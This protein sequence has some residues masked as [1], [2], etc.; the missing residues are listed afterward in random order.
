ML[1]AQ[2][3]AVARRRERASVPLSAV[4][5]AP[6]RL[7]LGG[8]ACLVGELRLVDLAALEAWAAEQME[9][10]LAGLPPAAYDP[11]PATRRGR[12]LA[13][14]PAARAW[15]PRFGAGACRDLLASPAGMVA[16][17]LVALRRFDASVDEAAAGQIAGSM[18]PAEWGA[19]YRE[20]YGSPAWREVL[21]ELDPDDD[22][23]DPVDWCEAVDEVSRERGWSYDQVG[24]LTIGQWR[25][26]RSHGSAPVYRMRPRP[27]ET[28]AEVM[29]RE[30]A[31]FGREG[32]RP[33]AVGTQPETG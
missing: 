15:P 3:A 26:V 11:E 30:R 33:S 14:W 2:A 31:I 1:A 19:F 16:T 24:A 8:R 27:G 5:P 32:G 29:A 28:P 23:G 25:C 12:L 7:V 6:R 9:H 13:I 4:L 20:A 18:T 17:V 22:A 10:P 21:A